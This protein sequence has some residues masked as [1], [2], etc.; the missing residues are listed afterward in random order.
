[1]PEGSIVGARG[2][3]SHV[4]DDKKQIHCRSQRERERE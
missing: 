4:L 1:M 3:R 2:Y